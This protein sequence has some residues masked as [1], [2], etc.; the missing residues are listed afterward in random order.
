MKRKTKNTREKR[1]SGREGMPT[2]QNT[3]EESSD[4]LQVASIVGQGWASA[5]RH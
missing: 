3:G 1:D 4:S 5:D 2:R